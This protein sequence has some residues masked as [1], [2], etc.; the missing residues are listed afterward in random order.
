MFHLKFFG[1]A[2]TGIALLGS[3]AIGRA[4]DMPD[5]TIPIDPPAAVSA[6]GAF[7]RSAPNPGVLK[8]SEIEPD[9][10]AIVISSAPSSDDAGAGCVVGGR[11]APADGRLVFAVGPI[12]DSPEVEASAQV[13]VMIEGD[14]ATVQA[15]AAQQYCAA[16]LDLSGPYQREPLADPS[17]KNPDHDEAQPTTDAASAK[18]SSPV[19]K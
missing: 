9:V 15:V 6:G 17:H 14:T 10:W 3:P 19:G 7:S 13:T 5:K 2:L 4:Q 16:D 11:G 1:A 8:I 12:G 18:L